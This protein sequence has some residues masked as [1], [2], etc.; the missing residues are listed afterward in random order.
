[1]TNTQNIGGRFEESC[2]YEMR[3]IG[4][5]ELKPKWFCKKRTAKTVTF[6]RFKNPSE[7]MTR[8][9]KIGFDGEEFVV[10]GN[11]SMAPSISSRNE[12]DPD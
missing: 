8:R 5:S 9:I 4:D 1:M 3:F 2:I 12:V 10:D 6:E 7:T 11:Y